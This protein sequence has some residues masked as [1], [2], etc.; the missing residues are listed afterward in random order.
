MLVSKKLLLL[1]TFIL[2]LAL[3]TTNQV[4]ATGHTNS[5]VSCGLTDLGDWLPQKIAE[6]SL[7]FLN[8]PL[9]PMLTFIQSLMIKSVNIQIFERMHAIMKYILS[10]FYG[11][12]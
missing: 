1:A 2:V 5:T 4:H 8:A 9:H 3:L 12:R 11:F 10:F 7:A 6:Y